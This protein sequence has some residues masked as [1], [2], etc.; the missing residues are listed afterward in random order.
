MEMD[1]TSAGPPLS[2]DESVIEQIG[3]QAKTI[4]VYFKFLLMKFIQGLLLGKL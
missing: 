1:L 3:T 2:D 4:M